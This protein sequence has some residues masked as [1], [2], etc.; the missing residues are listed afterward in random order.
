MIPYEAVAY[1]I[2]FILLL[3]VASRVTRR[4]EEKDYEA[5]REARRREMEEWGRLTPE[6]RARRGR[7]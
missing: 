7:G 1:V 2:G 5:R 6:E 4:H 3:W